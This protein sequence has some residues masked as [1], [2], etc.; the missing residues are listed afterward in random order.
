MVGP[1]ADRLLEAVAAH[2]A[3]LVLVGSEEMECLLRSGLCSRFRVPEGGR[4]L[5]PTITR[6]DGFEGISGRTACGC[7]LP[8]KAC[9]GQRK[10]AIAFLTARRLCERSNLEFIVFLPLLI[11]AWG[12]FNP[13]VLGPVFL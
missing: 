13:A 11:D 1:D 12:Q 3:G 2:G 5:S 7:F 9:G 4:F 6:A 10:Q 8:L